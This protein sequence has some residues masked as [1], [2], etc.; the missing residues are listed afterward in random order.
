MLTRHTSADAK[1]NPVAGPT[2]ESGTVSEL[3]QRIE[4]LESKLEQAQRMATL[5]E[6]L[7][8]TT[9]EFNNVLMSVMNYTRMALRSKDDAKR[10]SHLQKVLDASDRAAR[11]S[12]SILGAARNRSGQFDSV[13]LKSLLDDTLVLMEREYRKYRVALNQDVAD[14]P[15]ILAR[16]N[17]IQQVILN[18]LVNARQAVEE[19][20]EVTIRLSHNQSD[21]INELTIRDNG[22][23]IPADKL[24]RIFDPFFTTKSGPDETGRG[25]TGLGLAACREIIE[26]H[27]G[28][29]RVAST[30]G[31]GTAFTLKL[32]V[33][34]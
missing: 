27:K 22:C 23:G 16:G 8:T 13:D 33:A 26:A 2:S 18:L 11:I 5:G 34:A 9:H 7:S 3:K 12:R 17:E 1:H 30:E 28:R 32:P 29:I 19:G 21:G 15:A 14:V 10:Q 6:L 24:P 31:K 4:N 20:G 25:G